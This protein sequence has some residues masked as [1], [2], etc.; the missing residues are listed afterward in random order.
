[1]LTP[2]QSAQLYFARFGSIQGRTSRAEFWWVYAFFQLALYLLLT[3]LTFVINHVLGREFYHAYPWVL[4]VP[5][6]VV[7]LV[8]LM[9][10]TLGI[11]RLHD[12]GLSGWLAILLFLPL[13]NF[14]F[15]IIC[16][17]PS[18]HK[19]N[20]FGVDPTVNEAQH[21]QYYRYPH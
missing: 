2:C 13:L 7:I 1:M 10:L 19:T 11:R 18:S 3:V 20:R 6:L 12:L 16:M 21:F 15:M 14:V 4:Y 17:F 9:A 8:N 5:N